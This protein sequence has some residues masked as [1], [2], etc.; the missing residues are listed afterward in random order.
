MFGDLLLCLAVHHK[1]RDPSRPHNALVEQLT[2]LTRQLPKNI[3]RPSHHTSQLPKPMSST[4]VNIFVDRFARY[5]L[6]AQACFRRNRN[7]CSNCASVPAT[8]L[9]E[10]LRS[11]AGCRCVGG[12]DFHVVIDPAQR[13]QPLAHDADNTGVGWCFG[14]GIRVGLALAKD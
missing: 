12:V 5:R 8:P 1:Y 10:C 6:V 3:E 7:N 9:S 4:K 11:G 14:Q 13:L 2:T